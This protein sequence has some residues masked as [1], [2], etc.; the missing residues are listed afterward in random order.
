M[1]AGR[2]WLAAVLA[3]L[4]FLG[5][6][7]V[8]LEWVRHVSVA[9][10]PAL[11]AYSAAWPAV[12]VALIRWI[13]AGWPRLP[14]SVLAGVTWVSLE[15]LRAEVVFDAWPFHL[16]GHSQWGGPETMLASVGGIW[17]VGMLV[18]SAGGAVAG[19]VTRRVAAWPRAV[20]A[21]LPVLL[22]LL[23]AVVSA[24]RPSEAPPLRVLGV[25][26]NL[27]Q[28]NKIGWSAEQ[29][30][31][32]VPAFLRQTKDGLAAAEADLVVWPETMVPGLG[33]EPAT[34]ALLRDIGSAAT[35]WSRWPRAIMA[36]ATQSGIPWIVGTPTWVDVD[37]VDG[38]LEP[39]ARFNSGV[40]VEPGGATSRV[41]KVFLT[42]F[43]E[44]MP[45]VRAW[46][47]LEALVMDVGASGM[48]F[49]LDAGAA[50]SRLV[51]E[52][53]DIGDW[54]LAVPIC[55]ED[56]VP[57]VTRSM[58]VRDGRVAADVIVNISN[59]GWFGE[60]DAG[61]AAHAAAAA[62]RA[63]EMGR[64][65]LRVANTGYSGLYLPDGSTRQQ[66]QARVQ[67]T[68]LFVIPRYGGRTLQAWWGNWVPRL[69]L[70]ALFAGIVMRWR[71]GRT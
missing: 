65:M 5:P 48:R 30:A 63:V 26:T 7:A 23:A 8:C 32:D 3:W 53:G 52:Y 22:I 67:A 71:S 20:E 9:G 47:W 70:L 33:F 25:Q 10:Y 64:P 41:D 12:F 60:S 44:T 6:W 29:Q 40:L 42:P 4:A 46:P 58:C 2:G 55:F 24:P 38:M 49:N 11:V 28:S 66:T 62:W 39:G 13:G 16:A 45:Y 35:P 17:L 19:M 61:R 57:S 69:C 34:L 31:E 21:G 56:A 1:R 50:P 27:P 54:W 43:G 37:V 59:D 15:Y 14:W 18:V 36:A 68:D 51:L